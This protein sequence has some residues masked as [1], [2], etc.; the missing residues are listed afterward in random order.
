V[1]IGTRLYRS[2]GRL[3]GWLLGA[4]LKNDMGKSSARR[5]RRSAAQ[6]HALASVERTISAHD[7]VSRC[8]YLKDYASA[9][10]SYRS[11]LTPG[12]MDADLRQAEIVL[13]GDYHALSAA[14]AYAAS[15]VNQ[16]AQGSRPVLFCVEAILAR[17]QKI[18]NEWFRG[19]IDSEELR[20]RIRFDADWGYD[21]R[22]YRELLERA[23]KVAAGVYGLDCPPRSDMRTIARRDRHAATKVLELRRKC[24]EAVIV[25]LFG[26]SHLAPNHLPSLLRAQLPNSRI[27]TVLQNVDTLYWQAAGEPGASVSAV[28]VDAD[29]VCAFTSTPLEKYE[30]YRLYLEQWRRE[31]PS[32]PDLAPSF[33]NL[34]DTLSRFLN[35]NQQRTAFH[36]DNFPEV[37]CTRRSQNIRK[38]LQRAG[39]NSEEITQVLTALPLRGS[40]YVP[41]ARTIFAHRFLMPEAA[42]E[43]ARFVHHACRGEGISPAAQVSEEDEFY[44]RVIEQAIAYLG[45]KILCPTRV[46]TCVADASVRLG[47]MLANRAYDAYVAG[48]VNKRFLCALFC[49]PVGEPGAAR[50]IYLSTIAKLKPGCIPPPARFSQLSPMVS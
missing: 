14:Q 46:V 20:E 28:R 7:S 31:R 9:F 17:D 25:V 16:L 43:A 44:R 18:L 3:P 48:K 24:P 27:V 33:Y 1:R 37:S 39:L 34:I 21:W 5:F 45:S 2:Q 22:P 13:V 12:E 11:I 19:E 6:L 10:Q 49:A 42:E 23:R 32:A 41:G 8:Q 30:N 15:I 47:Q 29:V 40:C 26:E 38:R 36:P 4:V 50:E 35:L